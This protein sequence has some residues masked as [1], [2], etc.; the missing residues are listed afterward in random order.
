MAVRVGDALVVHA[1]VTHS[2]GDNTTDHTRIALAQVYKDAHAVDV[3]PG[4]GNTRSWAE[5]PAA[6]GGQL[7]FALGPGLLDANSKL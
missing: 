5:L 6:R 3:A 7:A 2:V 1:H 4:E